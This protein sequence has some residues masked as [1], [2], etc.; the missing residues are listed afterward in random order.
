MDKEIYK[1]Y[2]VILTGNFNTVNPVQISG[3]TNLLDGFLNDKFELKPNNN[4]SHIYDNYN[5]IIDYKTMNNFIDTKKH[6][7]PVISVLD[8]VNII[9][10][11]FSIITSKFKKLNSLNFDSIISDI[12][13]FKL[14]LETFMSNYHI[15]PIH[16]K[17]QYDVMKNK[18]DNALKEQNELAQINKINFLS[19]IKTYDVSIFNDFVTDLVV[20]GDKSSSSDSVIFRGRYRGKPCFIKMFSLRDKNKGLEYELKIY[21]YII[22]QNDIA[23]PYYQDYFINVYDV[24]KI[25]YNDF[26]NMLDNKG[27]I[28][29]GGENDGKFYYSKT[30]VNSYNTIIP[31]SLRG[32]NN[33]FYFTVTEDIEGESYYS[34][35]SKYFNQENIVIETLFEIIYGIYLLNNKLKIIHNDNHFGNIMIKPE[36]KKKKYI[37]NNTIL[38]RSSNYRVCMYDFDLSYA[39][40]NT[41]LSLNN[42]FNTSI[43]RINSNNCSKDIWT[44]V[45]SL[46]W[47]MNID[48]SKENQNNHELMSF[49]KSMQNSFFNKKIHANTY[50]TYIYKLVNDVILQTPEQKENIYQNFIEMR[51]SDKYWN[52][53]CNYPRSDICIQP[54]YPDLCAEN[55]LK[56][57]IK[58]YKD[59]LKFTDVFSYYKKYLKYKKKYLE[60]KKIKTEF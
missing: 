58:H 5:K 17:T 18:I 28:I 52:S 56:R 23:K 59:I 10:I 20:F 53:F 6:N 50:K 32:N 8:I 46:M 11:E 25:K 13:D 57:Y 34:F 35:L 4:Y 42:K 1:T 29:D 55:V 37:I 39:V 60:L 30:K 3:F 31:P 16:I 21:K 45:N 19:E 51:T 38:E 41:N 44:I 15:L 40:D 49:Y 22:E 12:N 9:D 43:G 2:R 24:F 36:Q 27:I 7:I 54:N 33:F 26:F 14:E 47:Q 48:F